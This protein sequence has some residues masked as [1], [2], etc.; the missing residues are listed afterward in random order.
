M[1]WLI[2]YLSSLVSLLLIDAIWLKSMAGFYREKLGHLFAESFSY[3][4]AVFFYLLYALALTVLVV[5]PAVKNG[6]NWG[7][8]AGTAALLGLAAYGA[9]DLTNASTMRDWPLV[10]TLIDMA[11]GAVVTAL[12]ALA[13]LFVARYFL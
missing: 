4:P 3:G 5:L 8:V 12:G 6:W 10:V 13:A 9:Y 7:Y 1:T 2:V 11:W